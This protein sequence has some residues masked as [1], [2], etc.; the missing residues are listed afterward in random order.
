MSGHR[1]NGWKRINQMPAFGG[2]SLEYDGKL[3]WSEGH[4]CEFKFPI[5]YFCNPVNFACKQV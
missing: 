3:F 4:L 5:Y 2:K 1:G